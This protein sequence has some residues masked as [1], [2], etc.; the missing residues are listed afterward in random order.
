[1]QVD[2]TTD[3]AADER[4]ASASTAAPTSLLEKSSRSRRSMGEVRWLTRSR[5]SCTSVEGKRVTRLHEAADRQEV[6][7]DDGESERREPRRPPAVPS[8]RPLR[9]DFE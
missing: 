6:Q 5:R 9:Q 3:S 4:V 8:H 7:Q 2:N 1:M